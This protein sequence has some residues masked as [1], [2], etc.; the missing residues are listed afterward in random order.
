VTTGQTDTPPI[1]GNRRADDSARDPTWK[2]WAVGVVGVVAAIE[3]VTFLADD[4]HVF[5]EHLPHFWAHA[6]ESAL[7]TIAFSAVAL[8][9]LWFWIVRPMAAARRAARESDRE[10]RSRLEEGQRIGRLGYW[11]MDLRTESYSWSPECYRMLEVDPADQLEVGDLYESLVHPDDLPM[12]RD[13]FERVIRDG[14]EYEVLHRVRLSGGRVKWVREKAEA[15]MSPRGEVVGVRGIIQ[16]QT[17]TVA[18][19]DTLRENEERFRATFEQAAV[20]MAH[21]AP[22]GKWLRVNKKFHEMLGYSEAEMLRLRFQ[23]VTHPEDVDLDQENMRAALAGT[24]S[25]YRRKKRYLHKNGSVVWAQLTV[26]LARAADGAPL[27]FIVVVEEMDARLRAE[28]RLAE[29]TAQLESVLANVDQGIGMVGA[30]GRIIAL[31][32]AFYRLYDMSPEEY[33]P[34]TRLLDLQRALARRGVFGEGDPE[35]LALE[36]NRQAMA[37]EP[38]RYVRTMRNGTEL[39]VAVNPI[40]GG[41]RVTTFTDI[42]ERKRMERDLS[43]ALCQAEEANRAKSDFLATMSHELRTPLNAIL[44]FAEVLSHQY[45]G[46]M[47]Q[48]RY[49]EYAEDIETSGRYLLELINDVLDISKIEAGEY[50][51]SPAP[52][53]VAAVI[54]DCVTLIG[55][56]AAMD[57]VRVVQ[58]VEADLPEVIADRR[59]VK[60]MLLNLLS[61]AVKYSEAGGQISVSARL[62]GGYHEITVKDTGPGIEAHEIPFLLEPFKKGRENP[63]IS[64]EGAGLGLAITNSLARLHAGTVAVDSAVGRGTS[65]TIRLP[66]RAVTYERDPTPGKV[67]AHG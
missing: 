17:D 50:M 60:Q 18:L 16:D 35:E 7:K 52:L 44:G 59:A 27:Y 21:V 15:V 36:M 61:N 42:T 45:F 6:A 33:G 12:L 22:D 23:D 25:E 48:S 3:A 32:R 19:E 4:G 14:G 64:V 46:P 8:P 26:A 28:R 55:H 62:K 37:N 2:G 41:G 30:N 39:E 38:V 47:G 5:S 13:A 10:M 63:D 49:V 29:R 34:G 57:S 51:L 54:D 11:S 9:I 56:R 66:T 67:A 31:N 43:E 1:P 58:A 53:N 24:V 40:A 65:V 20:G